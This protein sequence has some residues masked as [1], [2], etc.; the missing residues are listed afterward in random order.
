M[1]FFLY[2][3]L[4]AALHMAAVWRPQSSVCV[5]ILREYFFNKI[6]KKYWSMNKKQKTK[7]KV[8]VLMQKTNTRRVVIRNMKKSIYILTTTSTN[9][10]HRFHPH[11]PHPNH[12]HSFHSLTSHTHTF[13]PHSTIIYHSFNFE[14]VQ[15]MDDNCSRL[16]CSTSYIAMHTV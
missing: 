12:T 13:H 9:H 4:C 2:K 6:T 11:P 16:K 14:Q 5:S 7:K 1:C 8:G 3:R 15:S 10:T